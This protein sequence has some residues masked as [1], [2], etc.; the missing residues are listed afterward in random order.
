M[1][2]L[3]SALLLGSL[4]VAFS[5]AS[6][7]DDGCCG[8]KGPTACAEGQC[9]KDKSCCEDKCGNCSGEKNSCKSGQCDL[10]RKKQS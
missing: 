8:P 10:K 4:F 1:K 7:A 6:T 9:K 5:C 3:K 2:Y